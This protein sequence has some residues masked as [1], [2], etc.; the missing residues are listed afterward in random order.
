MSRDSKGLPDGQE[1]SRTAFP[2][3]RSLPL[4]DPARSGD[5]EKD[6]RAPGG[7]GARAKGCN[8]QPMKGGGPLMG[9]V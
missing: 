7:E 9:R 1:A 3:P 8:R 2:A 6:P 4:E 5:L